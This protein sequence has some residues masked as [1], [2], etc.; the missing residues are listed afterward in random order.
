MMSYLLTENQLPDNQK[1][2]KNKIHKRDPIIKV[3]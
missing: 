3:A 1:L 2:L